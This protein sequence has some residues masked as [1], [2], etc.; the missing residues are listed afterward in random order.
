MDDHFQRQIDERSVPAAHQHAGLSSHGRV[1]GCLGEAGAIDVVGGVGAI[2]GLRN[3]SINGFSVMTIPAY[4]RAS[5]FL[6]N[7]LTAF[8]VVALKN[9]LPI[10][11]PLEPLNTDEEI[12]GEIEKALCRIRKSP[13]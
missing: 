1:D 5:S 13:G 6:T 8:P 7:G 3:P 9:A 4:W 11:H 12:Q 2:G 10:A